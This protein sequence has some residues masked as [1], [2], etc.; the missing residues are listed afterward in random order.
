MFFTCLIRV[1]ARYFILYE[2]I[3]EGIDFPNFF[4]KPFFIRRITIVLGNFVFSYFDKCIYQVQEFP[5]GISLITYV[6]Y[7]VF[8]K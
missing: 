6:Y 7:Q 4:H 3:V 8:C 1:T 2:G 5:G